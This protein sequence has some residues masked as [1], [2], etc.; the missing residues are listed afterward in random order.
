MATWCSEGICRLG[1]GHHIVIIPT[2]LSLLPLRGAALGRAPTILPI[3][4]FCS[5]FSSFVVLQFFRLLVFAE[6]EFA[7]YLMSVILGEMGAFVPSVPAVIG[8]LAVWR[9]N[10]KLKTKYHEKKFVAGRLGFRV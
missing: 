4:R 10:N 8:I 5:R 3:D 1:G 2:A 9:H 6:K 7:K